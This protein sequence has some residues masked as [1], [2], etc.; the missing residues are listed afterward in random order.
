VFFK[1][2]FIRIYSIRKMASIEKKFNMKEVFQ[3]NALSI[4]PM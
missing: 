4:F 1:N 2:V 3:E